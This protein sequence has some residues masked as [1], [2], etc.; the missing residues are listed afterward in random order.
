MTAARRLRD[1]APAILVAVGFILLWQSAVQVFNIQRFI[2]PAPFAIG[3]AF[4]TYFSEIF[5]AAGYTAGE[6]VT[7]MAIG[8]TAGIGVGLLTARWA[9]ARE[10][11]LPFG[12]ALN[13]I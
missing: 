6:A 5:A 12:I 13:S 9:A 11:L 7:G 10:S 4:I 1:W 2:L 8:V 3:Q